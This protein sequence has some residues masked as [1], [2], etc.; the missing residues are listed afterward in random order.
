[1]HKQKLS[2]S[3]FQLLAK[4]GHLSIVK[5]KEEYYGRQRAVSTS[6]P[7]NLRGYDSL[8]QKINL[9]I[10]SDQPRLARKVMLSY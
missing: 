2:I 5:L 8:G 4:Q 10:I 9:G 3:V 7:Y 1:M 6:S